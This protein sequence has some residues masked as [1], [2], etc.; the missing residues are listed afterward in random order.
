M[1]KVQAGRRYRASRIGPVLAGLA[2]AGSLAGL[3]CDG[4]GA[5]KASLA[6]VHEAPKKQQVLD[7]AQAPQLDVLQFIKDFTDDPGNAN[8][9]YTGQLFKVVG[10]VHELSGE[11]VVLHDRL[12]AVSCQLPPDQAS[13]LTVGQPSAVTG[14]ATPGGGHVAVRLQA[15]ELVPTNP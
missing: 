9:K 14:F 10:T 6:Q 13:Q 8:A 5:K 12:G 4:C 2:L 3:G 7:R 15:C 1:S 11:R